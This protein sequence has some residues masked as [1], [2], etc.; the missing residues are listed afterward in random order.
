M[1][2][3]VT[4]SRT[5]TFNGTRSAWDVAGVGG[6]GSGT[7]GGGAESFANNSGSLF[8]L[9]GGPSAAL[10]NAMGSGKV[11]TANNGVSFSVAPALKTF[12]V[13]GDAIQFG[14]NKSDWNAIKNLELV[15][16]TDD[17]VE[18]VTIENFV[19]VRLKLGDGVRF[20]TGE[21]YEV[22]ILNA[23]RGEV[24][25]SELEGGLNLLITTSSNDNT[26]VNA[27][28]VTGS[29]FDDTM[30][31]GAGESFTGAGALSVVGGAFVTITTDMGGDQGS[32]AF[33]LAYGYDNMATTDAVIADWQADGAIIEASGRITSHRSVPASFL[34]EGVV[35][36]GIRGTEDRSFEIDG[37]DVFSVTIGGAHAGQQ[38]TKV[39]I[40]L[41]VFYQN[42]LGPN[43][44][45]GAVISLYDGDTLV[46]TDTF[47]SFSGDSYGKTRP[48]NSQIVIDSLGE[49]SF[50]TVRISAIDDPTRAD[51]HDFLIRGVT[52]EGL[53]TSGGDVVNLGPGR[54]VVIYDA[55]DAD[56]HLDTLFGFDTALDQLRIDTATNTGAGVSVAE[57]GGDTV[58]TFDFDPT[59]AIIV[60][61]VV[62]LVAGDDYVFV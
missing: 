56:N 23:K 34:P 22:E 20:P 27:F 40:D 13:T 51:P 9:S 46:L 62:G 33:S 47:Q 4:F 5:S 38:A 7:F 59:K 16:S 50:D 10:T 41:S 6:F 49:Y 54:D 42:E 43:V 26:W 1:A 19:D 30:T 45:E 28:T 29:S 14:L 57:L 3:Y 48:G 58:F 11:L 8:D 31:Y 36:L 52:F 37:P 17:M 35:G 2:S 15:L 55:T 25:A 60:K 18:K 39:T 12:E 32:F 24:D 53:F 21:T 61:G 44:F